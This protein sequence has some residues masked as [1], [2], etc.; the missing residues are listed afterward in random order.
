MPRRKPNKGLSTNVAREGRI[1]PAMEQAWINMQIGAAWL[2]LEKHV[3]WHGEYV[4]DQ[5]VARQ[6]DDGWMVVLKAYRRVTAYVTFISARTMSEAYDLAGEMASKG[7]LT[8]QV[9]KWP[10]TR[11][12]RLLAHF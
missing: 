8:W 12:K 4:L 10:S 1:E 2:D 11:L 7:S 3:A 6:D 5:V 9:D